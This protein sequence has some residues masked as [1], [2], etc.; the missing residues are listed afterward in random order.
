MDYFSDSGVTGIGSLWIA[1]HLLGLLT[2]WLVRLHAG[3]R[4]EAL[5]QGGFFTALLAMAITTVIGQL[6][7]LQ[8]WPMSAIT[9]ALMIVLAIVDLRSDESAALSMES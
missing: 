7:C 9:L 8:M 1:I 4:F 2:A 6:C 3:R 5:V